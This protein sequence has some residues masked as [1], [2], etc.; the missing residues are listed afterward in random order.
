LTLLFEI[1]GVLPSALNQRLHWSVKAKQ[2]KAQRDKARLLCPRWSGGPLL[3]VEL[4]RVAPRMLDAGDN[5][6]GA[7]KAIRDGIAARLGV[8]DGSPLVRWEYGQEACRAGDERV[9]VRISSQTAV[10]GDASED[11]QPPHG[12]R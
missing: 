2:T 3:V 9:L 5:L 10:V 1:P 7:F 8:D 4:V 11:S 6:S 12:R